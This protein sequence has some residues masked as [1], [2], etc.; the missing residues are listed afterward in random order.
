[1]ATISEFLKNNQLLHSATTNLQD[2]DFFNKVV[3][4]DDDPNTVASGEATILF[5]GP[6]VFMRPSE[7]FADLLVPIGAVQGF[8]D[9]EQPNVTPFREVGSRLKRHAVGAADYTVNIGKILTYHSNLRHALYAWVAKLADKPNEFIKAPGELNRPG[10]S[11]FTTMESDLFRMPFGL[12]LV[13]VT[14]GGN[15]VSNEYYERCL[16]AN[17]GK[18]VQAGQALIQEQVALTVTRKVPADGIQLNLNLAQT[19]FDI[20]LGNDTVLRD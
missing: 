8:Q 6:P 16:I 17:A 12:L 20:E 9:N 2:Y 7:N 19:A 11:H 13:T 10:K 3:Q 5:S 14:A 18:A 15:R 4:F 1:M